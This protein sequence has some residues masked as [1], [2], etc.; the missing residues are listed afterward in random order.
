MN[1]TSDIIPSIQSTEDWSD[2][3]NLNKSKAGGKFDP[4]R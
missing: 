2:T 4:E 1:E 3:S